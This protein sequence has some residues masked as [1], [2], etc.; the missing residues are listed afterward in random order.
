MEIFDKYQELSQGS[1]KHV[2]QPLDILDLAGHPVGR[3][4][5]LVQLLPLGH[6]LDR[7]AYEAKYAIYYTIPGTSP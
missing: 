4:H 5:V 1:F 2:Q 3:G 6:E 7:D